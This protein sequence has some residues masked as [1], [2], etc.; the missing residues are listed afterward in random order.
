MNI[1]RT[2]NALG[3]TALAAQGLALLLNHY[4]FPVSGEVQAAIGTILFAS[5]TYFV[6]K[7]RLA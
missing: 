7:G 2:T 5:L 6:G 4:G 1:D 3:I